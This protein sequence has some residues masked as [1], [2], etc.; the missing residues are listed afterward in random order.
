MIAG[1]RVKEEGLDNNLL[2]LIAADPMFGVTLEELQ[3]KLE[4]SKYVGRSKEQVEDYLA[5]VIKP[6]LDANADDLGL[7]AQI[8]V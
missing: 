1:K 2:E 8:N 7:T 6:I 3:A 5:D 4:P